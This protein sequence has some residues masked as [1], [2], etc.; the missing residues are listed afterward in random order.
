MLTRAIS[1]ALLTA[2]VDTARCFAMQISRS[3]DWL[4]TVVVH[5]V[6]RKVLR[7]KFSVESS[8]GK[9]FVEISLPEVLCR[10][11]ERTF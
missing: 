7:G 2:I 4:Q 8:C 10:N 5:A 6:R 11:E 1:T 9:F 3:A